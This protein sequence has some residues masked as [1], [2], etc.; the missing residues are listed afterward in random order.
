[1]FFGSTTVAHGA[2]LSPA[3]QLNIVV[4]QA[5][6][7]FSQTSHW[8]QP[9]QSGRSCSHWKV[10]GR[11]THKVAEPLKVMTYQQHPGS[12]GA[13]VGFG[14]FVNEM[15]TDASDVIFAYAKD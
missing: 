1:M 13:S 15:D 8:A 12:V 4:F 6:E 14:T 7:I 9:F 3:P 5:S 2:R 10:R 11:E